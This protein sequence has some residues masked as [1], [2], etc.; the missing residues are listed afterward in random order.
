MKKWLTIL[1]ALTL[2][3]A[4][5]QA[6]LGGRVLSVGSD[7]TYPPFESIDENGNTVGFDVDVVNAVCELTS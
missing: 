5:A 1:A 3:H 7:T 2:G 6:D 4:L